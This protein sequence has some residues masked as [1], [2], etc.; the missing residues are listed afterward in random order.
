MNLH[1]P[2]GKNYGWELA[3]FNRY[4]SKGIVFSFDAHFTT[5]GDHSPHVAAFLVICN[6]VIFEVNV[7][8]I[9]HEDEHE[10]GD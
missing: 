9:H 1:G 2:I 6:F 10:Q 3:L 4:G 8:N 7:Y 5:T